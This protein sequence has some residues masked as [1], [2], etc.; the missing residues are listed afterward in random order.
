MAKGRTALGAKA[1]G[2]TVSDNAMKLS[3]R[4]RRVGDHVVV[5]HKKQGWWWWFDRERKGSPIRCLRCGPGFIVIGLAFRFGSDEEAD[6]FWE[7]LNVQI[8][9]EVAR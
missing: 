6:I 2:D 9:P 8:V 1:G 3:E 5:H 7:V 4:L